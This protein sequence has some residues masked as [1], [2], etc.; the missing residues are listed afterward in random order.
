[1]EKI[2]KWKE[3]HCEGCGGSH[4]CSDLDGDLID[5]QVK[6]CMEMNQ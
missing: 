5:E 2:E 4:S 6:I 3:E 1:M